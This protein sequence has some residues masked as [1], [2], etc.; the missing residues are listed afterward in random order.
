MKKRVFVYGT[1]KRGHGNH[2]LLAGQVFL[3]AAST[4]AA[5]RLCDLG[6]FPG[7][8]LA[9]EDGVSIAGEIWEV[10]APCLR[11][12]DELEDVAGG[13]YE[14]TAIHLLPP[15]AD[16]EVEGYLFLRSVAGSRDAGSSWP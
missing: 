9:G 1:L 3:G 15:F 4:A 7:M 13:E 6:G 5:Y 8:V 14:R 2:H 10:D 16:R 11:R 12:L